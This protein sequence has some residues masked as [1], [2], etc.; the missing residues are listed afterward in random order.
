MVF[1]VRFH[2]TN[3]LIFISLFS[4]PHQILI[5][6]LDG[7]FVA[8]VD[9]DQLSALPSLQQPKLYRVPEE[10]IVGIKISVWPQFLK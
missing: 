4:K 9:G 3:I 5:S 6:F 8:R 1:V 10:Q 7:V 2:L